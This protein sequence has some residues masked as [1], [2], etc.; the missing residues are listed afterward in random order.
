MAAG[1]INDPQLNNNIKFV[2]LS[3]GQDTL[4]ETNGLLNEMTADGDG[5]NRVRDVYPD[6]PPASFEPHVA[7]EPNRDCRHGL[8]SSRRNP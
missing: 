3:N 8:A 5:V 2:E 6:H 7:A 4:G 1:R